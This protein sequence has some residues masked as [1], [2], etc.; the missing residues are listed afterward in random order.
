[1]AHNGARTCSAAGVETRGGKGAQLL[2][3][4]IKSAHF[5]NAANILRQAKEGLVQ[6]NLILQPL[7]LVRSY[8]R[9]AGGGTNSRGCQ[10][11]SG[12]PRSRRVWLFMVGQIRSGY[13][14]QTS[15]GTSNSG[16]FDCL[17]LR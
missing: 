9:I 6:R 3:H 11:L 15:V 8:N 14:T 17:G 2:R 13:G 5:A 16:H 10:P 12:S 4:G 7:Q 1:M